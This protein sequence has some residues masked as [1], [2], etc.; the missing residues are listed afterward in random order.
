MVPEV[1][2]FDEDWLTMP[3]GNRKEIDVVT[4]PRKWDSAGR[5]S[6]VVTSS[7]DPETNNHDG[8]LTTKDLLVLNIQ[9]IS[10]LYG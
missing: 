3:R 7:R 1:G 10:N 8:L 5:S 9:D 2:D 6:V 4:P